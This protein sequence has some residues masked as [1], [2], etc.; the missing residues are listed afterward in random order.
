MTLKN[1]DQIIE[2]FMSMLARLDAE[3]NAYQT[4]IYLYLDD[5]GNGTLY[6]FLNVGGNSWLNDAHILLYEDKPH[7]EDVAEWAEDM[8][9]DEIA[10]ELLFLY[11]DEY[12]S[13]AWQILDEALAD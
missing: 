9:T 4:D 13:T 8:T 11:G 2:E 1:Y 5:E 12:L 3:R 10:R 7:Y 6:E